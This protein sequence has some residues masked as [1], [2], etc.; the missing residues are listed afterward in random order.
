MQGL[1]AICWSRIEE[2]L[3]KHVREFA[4][5]ERSCA[6]SS[7]LVQFLGRNETIEPKERCQL[8]RHRAIRRVSR[9]SMPRGVYTMS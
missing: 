2:I 3:S 7:L 5:G 1:L 6:F 8:G 4:V 9:A